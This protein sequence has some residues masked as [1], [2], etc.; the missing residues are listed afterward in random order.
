MAA[1]LSSSDEVKSANTLD[2][3]LVLSWEIDL[4]GRLSSARRSAGYEILASREELEAAALILTAQVADTYFQII[5]QNLQL[6][7]LESQV[8]SGETLLD[9]TE[10]RFAYG[11]ASVVDVYQQRQQLASTRAQF[12]LVRSR[13]RTLE[14]RLQ[15]QLGNAPAGRGLNLAGD[16]PQVPG[17]PFTGIPVDL[18][19][20][21]PD[22]RRIYNQLVAVDSL[23]AEAVADRLPNITLT[24]TTKFKDRIATEGLLLS[25][26]LEAAA[27]IIDWDKRS[28]EVEIREALFREELARYSHAYLTAIEEVENALWQEHHQKELLMALEDQINIAGSNLT[29]TRNRYRQGLT[30]YLPVLTALQSLQEL[31]RDIISKQRELISYRIL[32]YRALGGS[33]LMPEYDNAAESIEDTNASKEVAK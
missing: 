8:T 32:L 31:E 22:L 23:I 3:G 21:R 15:V 24:G 17:L 29:E 5:E 19:Q 16:F 30:D 11:E 14:N 7:L 2:A 33:R 13:L 9:L 28:S 12:P 25:L 26:L 1:S 10:L 18:L 27:P 20:N 4:W 6:R